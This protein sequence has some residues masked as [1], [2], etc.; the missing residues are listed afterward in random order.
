LL[1]SSATT[2]RPPPAGGPDTVA[3]ENAP[4]GYRIGA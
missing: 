2:G 4:F 1:V 3:G